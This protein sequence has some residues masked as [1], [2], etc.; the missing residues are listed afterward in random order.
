M[1]TEVLAP[2]SRIDTYKH[3]HTSATTKKV[4]LLLQG[5]PVMPLHTAAANAENVFVYRAPAV[6]VPKA[7][8][9]VWTPGVLIYWDNTNSNFTTTLT[10]NTLAGR[11]AVAAL[12][13]DTEGVIDL[14]PSA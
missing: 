9:Q 12:S 2:D 5:K 13:A 6:K 7:A 10:G 11:I 14:D 1:T 8:A 4:F 3:T